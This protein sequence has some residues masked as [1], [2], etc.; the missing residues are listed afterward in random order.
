M[1]VALSEVVDRLLEAGLLLEPPATAAVITG[2]ADDSRR[3]EPGGLYCAWRGTVVD[4]H[5]FV[6]AARQA[7]AAAVL[8]E[9]PVPDAG[10]PQV[11]VRDGRRAASVAA[12]AMYGDPQRELRVIGVTGTNG[13]TTTVWILQH[14]LA[15]HEPSAALG[16]LGVVLE[17]RSVLEG[18]GDLT[19]PGP[20]ALARTLRALRDRGVRSLALEASSHALDQ[21]R[22]HA[23]RFDAAVFTNLSRD[24]LDYHGTLERY[25]AAKLSLCDLLKSDGCAVV[26]A[27]DPAWL[28]VEKSAPRVMRFS[29]NAEADVR[30]CDVALNG[31]GARF[32]IEYRGARVAARLPLLGSFNVQNALGAT[33]AVVALG[34]PLD[35]AVGRLATVPQVP[36]RLERIADA[37]CPVLRDYAHT[38][39]ALESALAT[40][41]PLV[42]GRLIVVFGA[43]G[44]RDAGKRPLMGAA[45]ERGADYAI[46]TSDNPRTED[47]DRIIDEIVAGMAGEPSAR[48]TDRRAAIAHALDVARPEDMVLLAGKGHETYQIQGT[49]KLPFDERIVVDELIGPSVAEARS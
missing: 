36:G 41:R 14:L 26:N 42:R 19:T 2:I 29:S 3:V 5:D 12:A 28:D 11:V 10:I 33:A 20:V 13:K 49:R 27:D 22:L 38:P 1:K 25:R 46:V 40:L 32:T 15:E 7:G 45:A 21:G 48:I 47:A 24:H 16:T 18:S 31:A 17:D 39:D 44:D 30:A 34:A 37:P 6:G 43:G 23:L 9:R 35:G 4:S 8:V